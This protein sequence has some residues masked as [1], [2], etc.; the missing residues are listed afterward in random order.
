MATIILSSGKCRWG[1]CVFCGWGKLVADRDENRV[2]RDFLR[3]LSN[4]KGE[5]TL[6]IFASGSFLDDLQFSPE[7]RKWIVE[8]L[9][10]KG[11]KNL[12]IESRPEFITKEK[13]EEFKGLNLTV[14][15]GLEVADDEVLK[16]LKKG[17]TLKDFERA[18][19][20]IHD[21]GAKLRVYLLVNPPFVDDPKE[22][23]RKSVEYAKKFADSIVAINC[24]PH[25]KSELFDMWVRGEWRPLDE[26]E[27]KEV[28]KGY[29]V[30]LDFSNYNFIPKFPKDKQERIVGVSKDTLLHPYYEVWQDYF[31]RFYKV[32]KGKRFALFLPCSYIKPY[33]RSPTH[34]AILRKLLKLPTYKQIHQ[35][36]ISSPGVIPREFEN[37]YPFNSYEWNEKDETEEIKKLYIDVNK[38]RIKKYL[39]RHKYEKVFSYLKPDSES[40]KALKEACD[41]LG[42]NLINLVDEE[43]YSELKDRIKAR[44][45]THESLLE[46]MYNKL[47]EETKS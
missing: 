42:I 35:I 30:E 23:F 17:I 15:I 14:A 28:T 8:K 5:D 4:I 45:L 40:Y 27:F 22:S 12:T 44:I 9:K 20:I 32:P 10:E 33:R 2:K 29:D 3:K 13:L 38:E 24:Y 43:K 34:R 21:S 47:L 6:S 46:S 19:K 1:K 16:K 11:F 25:S 37:Y 18:A 26:E 31:Q 41:E 7:L 36:M 39:R